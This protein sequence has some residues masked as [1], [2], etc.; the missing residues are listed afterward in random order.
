MMVRTPHHPGE[1]P[2]LILVSELAATLQTLLTTEAEDAARATGWVRRRCQFGGASLVQTLV[3]GW[4]H[5]PRAPVDGLAWIAHHLEKGRARCG[6]QPDAP[7]Q[8]T[9]GQPCA[10]A[11]GWC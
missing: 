2:L 9:P 10:G 11:S 7:A 5:D 4:L 6:H 8:G 1:E 3:L